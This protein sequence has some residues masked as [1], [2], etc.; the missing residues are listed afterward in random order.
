MR[1]SSSFS[2]NC[3]ISRPPAFCS[4]ASRRSRNSGQETTPWLASEGPKSDA[5]RGDDVA[6]VAVGAQPGTSTQVPYSSFGDE[7]LHGHLLL[8]GDR[9]GAGD[10]AGL[11]VLRAPEVDP[12]G[13]G[14]GRRPRPGLPLPWASIWIVKTLQVRRAA[15]AVAGWLR[16]AIGGESQGTSEGVER[17]EGV[18]GRQR[19]ARPAGPIAETAVGVPSGRR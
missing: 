12:Q 3:Q 13:T 17:V 10:P 14:R 4:G 8:V 6:R 19:V 18:V 15:T 11:G 2:P 9:L 5:G 7:E 16:R 1:T